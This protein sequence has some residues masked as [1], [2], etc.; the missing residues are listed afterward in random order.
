M[1][2]NVLFFA[3]DPTDGRELWV[4]DGLFNVSLFTWNQHILVPKT[5]A[6]KT[7]G[8]KNNLTKIHCDPGA[9]GPVWRLSN[10]STPGASRRPGFSGWWRSPRRTAPGNPH[11]R[12]SSDA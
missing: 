3:T 8:S 1:T 2:R 12:V 11:A 9:N 7:L 4:T 5:L 10:V 6:P